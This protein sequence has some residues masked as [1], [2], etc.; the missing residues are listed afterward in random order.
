MRQ[1][2]EHGLRLKTARD[3]P[4]LL[5]GRTLTTTLI[6]PPPPGA[7][8]AVIDVARPLSSAF[9]NYAALGPGRPDVFTKRL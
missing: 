7:I 4:L 2:I 3:V 9:A 6:F 1:V 8:F 5:K